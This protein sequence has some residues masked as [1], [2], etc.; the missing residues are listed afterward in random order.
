MELFVGLGRARPGETV[1][2]VSGAVCPGRTPVSSAPRPLWPGPT[3]QPSL[4]AS[5][6]AGLAART[7]RDGT[8]G[9]AGL[10]G[11]AVA[12]PGF[13]R[14]VARGAGLTTR[15]SAPAAL[16]WHSPGPALPSKPLG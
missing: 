11:L 4:T 16:G 14:H 1:R 3:D 2:L 10:T 6:P 9:I 8:Q 7:G 13:G 12:W 15:V 5:W